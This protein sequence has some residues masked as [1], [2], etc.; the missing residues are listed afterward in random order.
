MRV[1]VDMSVCQRAQHSSISGLP[2]NGIPLV[3]GFIS[4]MPTVGGRE[5]ERMTHRAILQLCS[6]ARAIP[7]FLLS[8]FLPERE[9]RNAPHTLVLQR[10]SVSSPALGFF[11]FFFPFSLLFPGLLSP[12]GELICFSSCSRAVCVCVCVCVA[13]PQYVLLLQHST[14]QSQRLV[15][16]I[17]LS[18][19]PRARARNLFLACGFWYRNMQ[20]SASEREKK[21]KEEGL[22]LK[23]RA[24]YDSIK[25]FED[26]AASQHR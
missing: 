4:P 12:F 20:G 26:Q 19:L 22:I 2:R 7:S 24:R 16:G 21:G 18:I 14:A 11:F 10:K 17:L 6:I 13:C 25:T 8:G 15:L 9:P 23:T 1:F 3:V 5:R